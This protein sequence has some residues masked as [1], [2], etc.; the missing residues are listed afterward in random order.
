MIPPNEG[1]TH[2]RRGQHV[3]FTLPPLDDAAGTTGVG[4][5]GTVGAILSSVVDKNS[6]G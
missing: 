5:R 3:D 1:G 6:T 4:R 2:N